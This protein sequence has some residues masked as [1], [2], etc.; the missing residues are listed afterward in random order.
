MSDEI[1]G[2][3]E[4]REEFSGIISP[5]NG[6]QG[7]QQAIQTGLLSRLIG[8]GVLEN[9]RKAELDELAILAERL[10]LARPEAEYRWA[11]IL[12]RFSRKLM[13]V[14]VSELHFDKKTETTLIKSLNYTDKIYFLNT[15]LELKRFIKKCGYEDY[16]FMDRIA[17]QEKKIFDRQDMKIE[18]RL[19]IMEEIKAKGEPL[20]VEELA[21]DAEDLKERGVC[22]D[23]GCD[24][25]LS[26]LLDVV[27]VDPRKN[28]AELLLKEAM[29]IKKNPA[30]IL[31][32]K[33]NWVK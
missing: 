24:W 4:L 14:A 28:K 2:I 30:R 3:I 31:I 20:T 25:I 32:N 33:V 21:V 11:L 29:K 1:K 18:N 12:R 26:A 5:P 27:I 19:Y 7:L 6:A 22:G 9:A 10:D 13:E 16:Y 8:E 17:R 23:S 15:K